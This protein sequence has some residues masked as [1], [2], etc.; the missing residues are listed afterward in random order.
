MVQFLDRGIRSYIKQNDAQVGG[1]ALAAFATVDM[2]AR[3]G[4][5]VS[6]RSI[7]FGH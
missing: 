6:V 4:E 7:F 5:I 1:D 2:R 3:D